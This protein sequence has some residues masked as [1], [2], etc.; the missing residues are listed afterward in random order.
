M[1]LAHRSPGDTGPTV[2]RVVATAGRRSFGSASR[3][4]WMPSLASTFSSAFTPTRHLGLPRMRTPSARRRTVQEQLSRPPDPGH[5]DRRARGAARARL[6]ASRAQ[7]QA[8]RHPRGAGPV[9]I[10][11]LDQARRR[12]TRSRRR[13]NGSLSIGCDHPLRR[14]ARLGDPDDP[15]VLQTGPKRRAPRQRAWST[16]PS[17][18]GDGD[19][20]HVSRLHHLNT[21]ARAFT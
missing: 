14:R 19:D 8:G 7:N 5:R 20:D 12:T 18:P 2:R 4:L 21:A 3:N 16:A 9:R 17:G 6:G 13:R 15:T 10:S 1:I 11:H